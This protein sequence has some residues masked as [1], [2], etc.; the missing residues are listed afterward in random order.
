MDNSEKAGLVRGSHDRM[1]WAHGKIPLIP[2][3]SIEAPYVVVTV[4]VD[5]LKPGHG[6]KLGCVQF[7][8]CD[9]G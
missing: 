2:D 7:L 9:A 4:H 3:R 8:V 5:M 6:R 1:V